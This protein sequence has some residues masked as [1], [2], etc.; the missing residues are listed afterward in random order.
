MTD[1]HELICELEE[2]ALNPVRTITDSM[3][4]RKKKAKSR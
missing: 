3:K 4:A 2:A 1:I